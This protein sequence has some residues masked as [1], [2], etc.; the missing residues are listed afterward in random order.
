MS[1][2]RVLPASITLGV[3][4][5]TLRRAEPDKRPQLFQGSMLTTTDLQLTAIY[6]PTATHLQGSRVLRK[7]EVWHWDV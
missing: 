2:R 4:R 5:L 6:L 3:E 7:C 1:E